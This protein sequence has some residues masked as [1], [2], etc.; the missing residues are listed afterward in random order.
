MD[1]QTGDKHKGVLHSALKTVCGFL[2]ST[3]GTLL[4]GVTDDGTSGA[5][6]RTT[7]SARRATRTP[8]GWRTR[9]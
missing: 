2:N 6:T 7:R 1:N 4:L 8:T 3:G 5:W 9:S